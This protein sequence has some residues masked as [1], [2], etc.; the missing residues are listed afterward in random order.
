MIRLI[1]V[2]GLVIFSTSFLVGQ[3]V[4]SLRTTLVSVQDRDGKPVTNLVRDSFQIFE[5]KVPQQITLFQ[6][7]DMPLSLGLVIDSSGSMRS[8]RARVNSAA[9]AFVQESNPEDQTF[10]VN[11]NDTA[12]VGQDFTGSIGDLVDAL[13]KLDTRG[14]T[15][16][17]D[18]I[19]LST[20]KIVKSGR[21]E[22]KVL[23]VISDGEDT[24]SKA[25]YESV[26]KQ[27]KESW[28][29]LYA[30]GLVDE[31]EGIPR[32]A[33]EALQELTAVTGGAA[34]F[35][36]SLDEVEELCKRIARDLRNRYRIGYKPTNNKIDGSWR[37]VTV[38]VAQP[39]SSARLNW[40]NR[41][42]YYATSDRN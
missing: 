1:A 4:S 3:N 23:L 13:E 19:I 22:T 35:P 34:Y 40:R 8:K 15:A 32:K 29:T 28:V 41:P 21:N 10:I 31:R 6:Q 27:L 7:E 37:G 24:S 17:Y 16:L 36:R 2:A 14:E 20:D 5:D 38:V 18:A 30:I 12:K 9:L 33:R 11:F 25:R 42:G 39:R 26:L